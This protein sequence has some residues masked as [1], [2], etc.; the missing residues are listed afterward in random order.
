MDTKTMTKFA[1]L[2]SLLAPVVFIDD[3]VHG[4]LIPKKVENMLAAY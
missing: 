4:F 3:D 1:V 2:I